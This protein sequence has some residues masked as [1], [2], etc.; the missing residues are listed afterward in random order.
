MNA[1]AVNLEAGLQKCLQLIDSQDPVEY[2]FSE[3]A[4]CLPHKSLKRGKT[5]IEKW[6][7]NGQKPK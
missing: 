4:N 2:Y 7:K 5:E 3:L 6:L 1:E